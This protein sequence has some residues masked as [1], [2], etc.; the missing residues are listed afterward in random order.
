MVSVVATGLGQAP[1]TDPLPLGL[2][3]CG[4][5]EDTGQSDG[6]LEADCLGL[7]PSSTVPSCVTVASCSAFLCLSLLVHE[8]GV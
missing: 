6:M 7:N 4:S 2:A 5:W 3:G 8:M 1:D